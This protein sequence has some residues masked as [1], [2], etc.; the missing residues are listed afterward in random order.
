M[1]SLANRV[2]M[3]TATTGTGTITLGSALP[4]F[5]SFSAGGILDGNVV[6]Y[7]IEDGLNWEVGSGTYTASG[8]T[9]SRTVAESSNSGS[10]LVLSGG[11]EVY[12]TPTLATF[13]ELPRTNTVNTFTAAQTITDIANPLVPSLS[14]NAGSNITGTAITG[15]QIT[16]TAGEFSCTAA[17]LSVGQLLTISGTFGGTG[18]ITGYANPTTYRISVT[19]GSTTFTLVNRTT[20]VALTTAVGTPTGL[21]Y[22]LSAPGFSFQQTW[23]NASVAFTGFQYNATDTA[24]NASSLLMDLRRNGTNYA[25]VTKDG[26]FVSHAPD[27]GTGNVNGFSLTSPTFGTKTGLFSGYNSSSAGFSLYAGGTAIG[28]CLGA[29]SPFQVGPNGLGFA[30]TGIA[31]GSSAWIVRKDRASLRFGNSDTGGSTTVTITIASPGVVSWTNSAFS[32]GTPV[33]FTTTGALPTGIVAGTV[34]YAVATQQSTFQIAT[35]LA[36]AL[37]GTA[38]NT[39]GTQSGTHTATAAS[40]TQALSVQNVSGISNFLGADFVINGSQGTGTGAGGSL[41][42]R[43]APAGLSGSAQNALATA[44]T[45]D[46]GSTFLTTN[47]FSIANTISTLRAFSSGSGGGIVFSNSGANSEVGLVAGNTMQFTVGGNG[48]AYVNQLSIGVMTGYRPTADTILARD[49]ANTLALK[50]GA[51][52]QE[53]RV[54]E[55]TTG[56]IYKA[57]LGNRQLM[58][59]AGAAFDNG[60]GA[61]AG[62]LTNS[63]VTGNPT[64]WIPIDDNG[65]TRYIPAW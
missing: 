8:T 64:K 15:V 14:L 37:A 46:G 51:N 4:G 29:T 16:G 6:F 9:L 56:T 23:N 57:I 47:P 49:A 60:A 28:G 2:K 65:T 52:A 42:F 25:S 53:F 27:N 31:A 39:S 48:V 33:V 5:Q 34:Y 3:T 12:I 45:I 32:V 26:V 59:I 18:S 38:I 21:T 19:N 10:P 62:T 41:V 58:K 11:A 36:N 7:V 44:L 22:T 20:N 63:P 61:H 50:N 13:N 24:S 55:T 43:V 30:T 40:N 1:P 54:Y 17:S 35:T